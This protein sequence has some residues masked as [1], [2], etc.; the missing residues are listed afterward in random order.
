MFF[1]SKSSSL[2]CSHSHN[3][4]KKE[5]KAI[6]FYLLFPSFSENKLGTDIEMCLGCKISVN[7]KEREKQQGQTTSLHSPSVTTRFPVLLN[8]KR[9]VE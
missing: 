5:P 2:C 3:N 1:F 4:L 6:K 8:R 9:E 7:Y